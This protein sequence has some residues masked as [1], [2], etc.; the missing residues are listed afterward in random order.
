MGKV[1]SQLINRFDGGMSNDKRSKDY[2]KYALAR[3]FDAF[4][5]PHKLVPSDGITESAGSYKTKHIRSFLYNQSV[6]GV[7]SGLLDAVV[8]GL[9]DHWRSGGDDDAE[10]FYYNAGWNDYTKSY[11]TV[12]SSLANIFFFYKGYIYMARDA[13]KLM[14]FDTNNSDAFNED[15]NNLQ[16]TYFI[17]HPVLH[18]LDDCAYFFGDNYVHQLNNT[19]WDDNVLTLPGTMMIKSACPYLNYLALGVETINDKD[20]KSIVYLWD[21]D[22]SLEELS[23]RIDFGNGSLK[24]LFVLDNK[25]MAVIDNFPYLEIKQISGNYGITINRLKSTGTSMGTWVNTN[26]ILGDKFYFPMD[27]DGDQGDR[28]GIW[29]ID[30]S[31]RINLEFVIDGATQINGIYNTGNQWWISYDSDYKVFYSDSAGTKQ[32]SVYE[33]LIIG[34]GAQNNKLSSV[35]VMTE[36]LAATGSYITL[37]YKLKESDSWTT[38]FSKG[39]ANDIWHEAINI[40]STGATLPEFREL[41]LRAESTYGDAITGIFYKAETK[42]DNLN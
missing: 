31:G 5:Y 29:S 6:T 20:K 22:S 18:P 30:S 41:F 17:A 34:E 19:V 16:Y 12:G 33:T 4:T 21:R 2:S 40:E 23:A 32:T 42:D 14:R 38:I 15:W 7:G 24:H 10:V 35:G 3:N 27:L 36:P 11:S 1:Y 8:W 9:G 26:Q 25:L 39:T 28:F 37:K 13:T